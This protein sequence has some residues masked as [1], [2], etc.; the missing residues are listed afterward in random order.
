MIALCDLQF[1]K[2]SQGLR[3]SF[4]FLEVR[5]PRWGKLF[6]GNFKQIAVVAKPS[7]N[8]GFAL[9]PKRR[10]TKIVRKARRS[11]NCRSK[12]RPL[13]FSEGFLIPSKDLGC[14][15]PAKIGH[16]VRVRQPSS[17]T[18]ILFEGKDLR[19]VGKT[20][21][22]GRKE[23]AIEVAFELIAAITVRLRNRRF[24]AREAGMF[25]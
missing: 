13:F 25:E 6:T 4:P 19:F 17:D 12:F 21:N 2:Q 8:R 18:V 14:E 7:S 20:T 11:S 1:C 10:V 5:L 9:M 23:D 3:V 22:R 24:F 15:R 16:L